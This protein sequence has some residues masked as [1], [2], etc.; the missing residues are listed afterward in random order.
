MENTIT[1]K[2]IDEGKSMGAIAYITVIGLIIAFVQ[3]NEKKN[4]FTA[5]HI[6]QSLGIAVTGFALGIIGVIPILG[7]IIIIFG[8][9]GLL[10]LWV[11][12]LM[13][14]LNG[15]MQPVP[16][17]GAKYNEWFAGISK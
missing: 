14:A 9:I 4:L 8:S 17:L 5:F 15:K 11:I 10:V 6:R 7:W 1:E 2:T 16:V 13:N 3:N 12:G